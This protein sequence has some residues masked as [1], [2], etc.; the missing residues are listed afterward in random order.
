MELLRDP[1]TFINNWLQKLLLTWGVPHT[2]AAQII[3]G[4]G[5]AILPL[6]AM[7]VCDLPDLV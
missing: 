4:V 7:H 5:A 1:V 6:L 3:S 2:L